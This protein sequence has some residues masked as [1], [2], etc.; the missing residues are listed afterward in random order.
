MIKRSYATRVGSIISACATARD[1]RYETIMLVHEF[2]ITES[3]FAWLKCHQEEKAAITLA[4]EDMKTAVRADDLPGA[5]AAGINWLVAWERNIRES[6][7]E[8]G[9][10]IYVGSNAQSRADGRA[11]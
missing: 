8:R 3:L 11:R 1:A 5:I 6:E 2:E 10:S 4:W 7:S 9:G